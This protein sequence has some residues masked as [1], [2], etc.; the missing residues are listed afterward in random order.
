[1]YVLIVFLL[2]HIPEFTYSMNSEERQLEVYLYPFNF[3]YTDSV[4]YFL[5]NKTKAFMLNLENQLI[6]NILTPICKLV[7]LNLNF[8]GKFNIKI[9]LY[10]YKK[11][12]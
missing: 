8:S 6:L 11:L 10:L 7:N 4:Q 2:L 1:M 3:E 12:R 9:K 5:E